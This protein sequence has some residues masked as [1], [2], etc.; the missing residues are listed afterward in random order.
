MAIPNHD[1]GFNEAEAEGMQSFVPRK[2]SYPTRGPMADSSLNDYTTRYSKDRIGEELSPRGRFWRTYLDEAA[3]LDGSMLDEYHKTIDQLLVFASLFSAV[4]T[5]FVNTA[6]E[7]MKPDYSMIS[8]CLL[9]EEVNMQ[10]DATNS[11]P[12]RVLSLPSCD[13]AMTSAPTYVDQL[14]NSIWV[15]SLTLSLVTAFIAVVVKQWLHQYSTAVPN[16]SPRDRARIRQSRHAAF[17]T[18]Q[19]PMIIGLLPVLM[20]ASLA[21]FLAGFITSLFSMDMAIA[22]VVAILSGAVYVAYGICLILPFIYYDCPYKT[23][24]TFLLYGPCLSVQKALA[25][26]IPRRHSRPGSSSVHPSEEACSLKEAERALISKNS[27]VVDREAISWLYSA[28]LNTSV[29]H[30][31]MQSVVGLCTGRIDDVDHVVEDL[32]EQFGSLGSLAQKSILDVLESHHSLLFSDVDVQTERPR[33]GPFRD[34]TVGLVKILQTRLRNRLSLPHD[35]WLW[36]LE[37]ANPTSARALVLA[38][39]LIKVWRDNFS[40]NHLR[41]RLVCGTIV[42]YVSYPG[43][44]L[45]GKAILAYVQTTAE[46]LLRHNPRWSSILIST[47]NPL[48]V[49]PTRLSADIALLAVFCAQLQGMEHLNRDPRYLSDVEFLLHGASITI[50]YMLRSSLRNVNL[51][52]RAA[53]YIT[54][55]RKYLSPLSEG[56]HQGLLRLF[57]HCSACPFT[58]EWFVSDQQF[59][60]NLMRCFLSPVPFDRPQLHDLEWI[61]LVK[62]VEPFFHLKDDAGMVSEAFEG[63]GGF[64]ALYKRFRQ[65]DLALHKADGSS[66]EGWPHSNE[67]S[68]TTTISLARY[69]AD[70]IT[71]IEPSFCPPTLPDFLDRLL[72]LSRLLIH[73]QKTSTLARLLQALSGRIA[74]GSGVWQEFIARLCQWT[75]GMEFR[76]QWTLLHRRVAIDIIGDIC[77][78]FGEGS[79]SV[80]LP[81]YEY[82]VGGKNLDALKSEMSMSKSYLHNF[83]TREGSYMFAPYLVSYTEVCSF[84]FYLPNG[85]HSI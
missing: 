42:D 30:V 45:V 78:F 19:V 46:S 8:A 25:R 16:S 58:T 59:C 75:K 79:E 54:S 15:V 72:L 6:S 55:C 18:W 1:E 39:E 52:R 41:H 68:D 84:R 3:H 40:T 64:P 53:C 60:S 14:V 9:V 43:D 66:Y 62:V 47:H 22:Y 5:T 76:D 69:A 82:V 77:E 74:P 11:A 44:T 2:G 27:T 26:L 56:V 81:Q 85:T 13:T 32:F 28:T 29:Q 67:G 71:D 49:S 34:T 37:S 35:M 57:T 65:F 33:L 61:V 36:V 17:G 4:V 50:D 83:L 80:E 12:A 63:E 51:T 38:T 31:V 10:R 24:L 70:R 21:L 48:N 73:G 7:N 23:P 20:H